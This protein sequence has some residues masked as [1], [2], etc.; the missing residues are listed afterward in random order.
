MT[1]DDYAR[2]VGLPD[3]ARAESALDRI[4]HRAQLALDHLERAELYALESGYVRR[5]CLALAL[6]AARGLLAVRDDSI[7]RRMPW[8][9]YVEPRFRRGVAVQSTG[10]GGFK[11]WRNEITTVAA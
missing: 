6:Y 11:R 2:S 3:A 7:M 8:V 10:G 1:R 4:E 5:S 9:Q